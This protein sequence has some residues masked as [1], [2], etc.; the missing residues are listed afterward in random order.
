MQ[1]SFPYDIYQV[2]YNRDVNHILYLVLRKFVEPSRI[3]VC[4]FLHGSH[5]GYVFCQIDQNMW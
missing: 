5:M 3:H 4:A 2:Q 1:V